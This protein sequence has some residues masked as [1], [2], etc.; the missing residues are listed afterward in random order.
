[1]KS[2]D[3]SIII[4]SYKTA[5]ILPQTL[6]SLKSAAKKISLEIIIVNNYLAEDLR[7]LAKH[8]LKPD[9]SLSTNNLGFSKGVN[10]AL[11]KSKG[12]Y[13]LLLNPD[14]VLV[15]GSLVDML[16]F[17]EGQS[18]LCVVS[19]RLLNSD[20]SSQGSV[21]RFP[22]ITNAFKKYF[23]GCKNC[24]GKYLPENKIQTVDVAVMA[25]MLIPR[26]VFNL[27]GML[28]ERFFLYYE[29]VEFCQRLKKHHIP[30]YYYPKAKVKH[31]HGASGNFTEHLKSPLLKSSKIYYGE[32]YS[33]VLNIV[34]WLGHKWQVIIRGKKYKD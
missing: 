5:K 1:M 18:D 6:D 24:F 10:L 27:V 12:K 15:G 32:T 30:V 7:F 17:A 22:S 20:G 21:F 4:V 26:S 11:K 13:A 19:P 29:D 9:V 25:A 33:K 2:I 34:L 8:P 16:S 3:V 28:D 23:L 31:L 14:C